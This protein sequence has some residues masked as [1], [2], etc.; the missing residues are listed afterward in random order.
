MLTTLSDKQLCTRTSIGV[1]VRYQSVISQDTNLQP[2][3]ASHPAECLM[4]S[5]ALEKSKET[6]LAELPGWSRWPHGRSSSCVRPTLECVVWVPL[7][8]PSLDI[9]VHTDPYIV[10]YALCDPVDVLSMWLTEYFPI[11]GLKAALQRLVGLLRPHLDGPGGRRLPLHQRHT[12]GAQ[13]Y[14]VVVRSSQVG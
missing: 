6:I 5:K 11:C 12:A 9:G 1:P 4:V 3:S 10:S 7:H 2:P 14:H 13:V 8:R